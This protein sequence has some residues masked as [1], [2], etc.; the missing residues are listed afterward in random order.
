MQTDCANMMRGMVAAA[1]RAYGHGLR[2]PRMVMVTMAVTMLTCF[3]FGL[4]LAQAGLQ[5]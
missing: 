2:G 1:A 4:L 5:E 3:T